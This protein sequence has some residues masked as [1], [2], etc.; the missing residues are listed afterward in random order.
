MSVLLS[1]IYSGLS[2]FGRNPGSYPPLKMRK[3]ETLASPGI[4]SLMYKSVIKGETDDYLTYA[5]FFNLEYSDIKDKEFSE[6]EKVGNKVKY[7]KKP[8]ISKNPV[9][10]K[11]S[12]TDFRFCFEKELYDSKA[13]VGAYRKYTPVK[14]PSGRPPKNPG[15]HL[16]CCKH[17]Y[18][19]IEILKRNGRITS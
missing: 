4:K 7:H 19:L 18:N 5:Q 8:S 17:V 6:A 12:C 16:G 11:C 14:P 1:K 2:A 9:S 13:L 3:L 10:L 15:H